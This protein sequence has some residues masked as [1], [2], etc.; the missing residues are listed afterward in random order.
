MTDAYW[1]ARCLELARRAQGRTSP[2]P[3][4][5]AVVVAGDQAVGEGWHARA[6]ADHAEVVALREAG[7]RAR[8]ATLYVNLE[9]CAH[10]GRTPPCTDAILAAGIRRVVAGMVDPHALV[11]GAGIRR[12]SQGG[13]DVSVGVLEAECRALNRPFLTAITRGRPLV[14]LKAAATLDGR[15]ATATGQSRWITGEE[16]RREGHVLRDRLDAILVGKGTA[17]ADDPRL[18]CRIPEGRDPVPVVLDSHLRVPPGARMFHGSQRALVYCVD[19]PPAGDH[20]AQLVQ[21]PQGADGR[22]SVQAVLQD[23]LRRGI[24]SVLVEGGG[25]VHR[26]FLEAGVVDRIHLYLAPFV[27]AGGPGWVGGDPILRIEDAGRFR[28]VHHSLVG[29]DLLVELE[30]PC[31]QA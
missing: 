27:L 18:D 5:G 7:D 8:G 24:H 30:A 19:S 26:A 1:M 23:L 22:P 15:I 28:C 21:V 10:F 4:V 2:N 16:A 14:V 12:L 31:S 17:L 9:P 6:G 11:N 3:L 29:E 13:L 20:P 25:Q